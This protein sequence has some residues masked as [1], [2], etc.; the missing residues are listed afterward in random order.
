MQKRI[1]FIA[2]TDLNTDG[3]ILNQMR[4]LEERCPKLKIDFVLLPDKPYRL[5]LRNV[6]VHSI[7]CLFRNNT[8]LRPI[9]VFEFTVKAI[10]KLLRLAPDIIHV[11]DSSVI[12]P[13]YLYCKL[14]RKRPVIIYDDHEIPNNFEQK[15]VRRRHIRLE[16]KFLT[17]ADT[18][19]F[20]NAERKE[21]L[22][23]KLS[24]KNHLTYFLNLPYY[25]EN[26]VHSAIPENIS[27]ILRALDL[28]IHDGI[29]FI[30]HQGVIKKERGERQLAEFSRVLPRDIK[31]M[32]V[33]ERPERFNDF[34]QKWKL[35]ENTFYFVGT[36]DYFHLVDF[37]NRASASIVM[38][39]P[40]LLNNRL[41][42]PNRFYL[43]LQKRIPVIVNKRNPVLSNFVNLYKCGFFIENLNEENID[44]IFKYDEGQMDFSYETV[45]GEQIDNFVNVYSRYI[46]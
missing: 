26:T 30:I 1:V 27:E 33:G 34:I 4:I 38:Y 15:G 35:N 16:N 31:I 36:V 14:N 44:S 41:C 40:E 23:Q 3:R 7:F 12:L 18:V 22:R 29:R 37:W 17:T 8:F 5:S 10:I 43:S 28:A 2:K 20:A 39:L 9:T 42:A 25:E 46:R 6:N 24:L 21:Y 32:L 19:I 11:H 13:V 45:R